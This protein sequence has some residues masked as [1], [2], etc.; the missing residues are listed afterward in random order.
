MEPTM[1]QT[2]SRIFDDLAKVMIDAAGLAQG[3]RREVDTL[4]RSQLERLL[5][6]MDVVTRE[7]FEA[8]REMAALARAQNGKLEAR[9]AALE[10]KLASRAG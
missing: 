5:S 4:V 2:R 3:A 6:G 9:I 8:V 1:P 10:A 7:E